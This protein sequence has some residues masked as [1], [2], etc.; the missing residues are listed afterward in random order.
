MVTVRVVVCTEQFGTAIVVDDIGWQ[1]ARA[2]R[3]GRWQVCVGERTDPVDVR[4]RAVLRALK[5]CGSTTR[6]PCITT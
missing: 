4:V 6:R 3:E 2:R 5:A 1:C